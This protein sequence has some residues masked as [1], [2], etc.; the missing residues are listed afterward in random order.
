MPRMT[1]RRLS[2]TTFSRTPE[3]ATRWKA[4]VAQLKT[5]ISCSFRYFIKRMG[6]MKNFFG[7]MCMVAPVFNMLYSSFPDRSK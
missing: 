5:V 3:L 1:T 6:N 2:A 7:R 4:A